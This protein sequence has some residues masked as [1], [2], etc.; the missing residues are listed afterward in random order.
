MRVG[1]KKAVSQW[2]DARRLN[3][4]ADVLTAFQF[5]DLL[6]TVRKSGLHR[7]FGIPTQTQWNKATGGLTSFRDQVMHPT[8]E[9]LGART[10]EELIQ[11]EAA[12]RSMLIEAGRD[13]DGGP[14]IAAEVLAETQRVTRSDLS[15]GRIRIPVATKPMFPSARG[16]LSIMLRG[17]ALTVTY[18]PR[19]GPARS[20]SGVL[21]V[22]RALLS[23]RVAP[24][25]RLTVSHQ[26]GIFRLG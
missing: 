11:V 1:G 2:E 5:S 6:T 8:S 9:F 17:M 23:S 26:D 15:A 16:T 13:P 20:R 21:S 18:D 3:I 24:D 25:E 19:N 10:I 7:R 4:D 14:G 12:L 22:G